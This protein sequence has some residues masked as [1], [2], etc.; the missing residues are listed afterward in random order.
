M[1][2]TKRTT[3]LQ[4][5]HRINRKKLISVYLALAVLL[6]C[7]EAV[8]LRAAAAAVADDCLLCCSTTQNYQNTPHW[9]TLRNPDNAALCSQ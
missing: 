8:P 7:S 9:C 4:W 3:A 2:F 1:V 6:L 5:S